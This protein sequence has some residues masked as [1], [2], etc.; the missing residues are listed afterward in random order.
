MPGLFFGFSKSPVQHTSYE[1]S[2]NHF[3]QQPGQQVSSQKLGNLTVAQIVRSRFGHS[4]FQHPDGLS[5]WVYGSVFSRQTASIIEVKNTPS[6]KFARIVCELYLK[7][8]HDLVHQINGEFNI[9]ILDQRKNELLIVN[10]R[11]GIRPWYKLQIHG[12][13]YFSPDMNSLIPLLQA[14]PK[15]DLEILVGFLAFNKI[16]LGN[17]TLIEEISVFPPASLCSLDLQ[18]G[19]MKQNI[20]WQLRYNDESSPESFSANRIAEIVDCYRA[21]MNQRSQTW[22]NARVGVSLSGG[23]DSR[24]MIAA[25]NKELKQNISAHTYGLSDSD[26]VVLAVKVAE[27]A[28]IKSFVYPLDAPDYTAFA[29]KILDSSDELDIFVQAAQLKFLREAEARIDVLMT[30]IDLDVTLGGIYLEPDIMAANSLEKIFD[31]IKLKNVVF[32]EI[33]LQRVLMP[34]LWT[35]VAGGTYRM[36]YDLLNALPQEN[37]AASYD[38][39]INQFSMRR[40]IMLR[41][42]QNRT[43]LETASPMYDYDFIDLIC[44]LPINQRAKHASFIPFLKSLSTPLSEITYQRT[45]LPANTPR[46]FWH[47]SEEIERQREQLYLKI[48]RETNGKVNIPYR[49]YYTNY[50]EWLR[51]DPSWIKMTDFLL[52]SHDARLYQLQILNPKVVAEMIDQ[53]RRAERSHRQR[54]IILMSL[55]LFLRRHF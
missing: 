42:A 44:A 18:S 8:G 48:W 32:G 53:H 10:D 50:D 15:P 28:G 1:L 36:A 11:F 41:Y 16:R 29:E 2:L 33:D 38:L 27:T 22:Q 26:E 14:T 34:S 31:L 21:A 13:I 7:F 9:L 25:L 6:E 12:G 40:I 30:G 43:Y 24:T 39:F 20:Y 3:S 23:L 55:E 17:R 51:M 47:E 45:M 46:H 5:V 4:F 37:P 52:L 35:Q 19:M 54:L 49:R